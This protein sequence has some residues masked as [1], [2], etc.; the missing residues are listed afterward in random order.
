MSK[1]SSDNSQESNVTGS[2]STE[3]T[4]KHSTD[5]DLQ[6]SLVEGRIGL[7]VYVFVQFFAFFFVLFGTPIDMFRLIGSSSSPSEA[8]VTTLWG[9]KKGLFSSGYGLEFT[10]QWRTCPNRLTRFRVAQ[11]F[12][13]ISIF[14]Y[15]AAFVLGVIQ[16]F[17]CAYLRWV[18]LALNVVG[19]VTLCIVWAAMVVTFYTNESFICAEQGRLYTYGS[20]FVLFVLAWILDIINIVSLLLPF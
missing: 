4:E 2:E 14:V 11:A 17:C 18:C 7:I 12:A 15:G 3:T 10:R 5:S 1:F 13:L 16:L 6:V 9:S 8:I 19:A 20:G